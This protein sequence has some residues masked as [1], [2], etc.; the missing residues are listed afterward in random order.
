MVSA[1]WLLKCGTGYRAT[2][3]VNASTFCMMFKF[4]S[5]E[6]GYGPFVSNDFC[7]CDMNF[8]LSHP[9]FLR[10]LFLMW[11]RFF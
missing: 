9:D 1:Y 4:P 6:G 10:S 5:E 8:V 3:C 7:F 2:E 11:N